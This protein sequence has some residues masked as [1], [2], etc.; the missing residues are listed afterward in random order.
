MS[1]LYIF[2]KTLT[3][4]QRCW[5]DLCSVFS[6]P[7]SS[8]VIISECNS[9][10]EGAMI[11]AV[12][13]C[14]VLVW[15]VF[16]WWQLGRHHHCIVQHVLTVSPQLHLSLLPRPG[17]NRFFFPSTEVKPTSRFT[18]RLQHEKPTGTKGF[19]S[20]HPLLANRGHICLQSR[21]T[22]GHTLL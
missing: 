10:G 21:G 8:R 4:P 11:V 9:Y 16:T 14:P 17:W 6:L 22:A 7:V 2:N 3:N 12:A 13:G 18:W 19:L 15:L 1:Y 5:T 20:R